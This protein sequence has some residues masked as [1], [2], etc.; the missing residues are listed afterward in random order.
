M[1]VRILAENMLGGKG[2]DIVE[3]M[4]DRGIGKAMQREEVT[5]DVKFTKIIV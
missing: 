2:F 4:L 3:R 5:G 1:L